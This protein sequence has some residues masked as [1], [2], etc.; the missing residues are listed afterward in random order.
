MIAFTIIPAILIL[1]SAFF[2]RYFPLSGPE[3]SKKKEGLH[4]IHTEK[5]KRT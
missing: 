4:K 1:I 3:W 5:E 2:I